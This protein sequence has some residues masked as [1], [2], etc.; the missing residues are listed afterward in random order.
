M[1]IPHASPGQAI[2]VRP[3]G[4]KLKSSVTNTLVK[5]DKLEVI[6]MVIPEDKEIPYHKVPG[7]ITIQCLEGLV[8]LRSN[9]ETKVL[10]P[11][12]MMY[13]KGDDLHALKGMADSSLLVMILL[14]RK[15]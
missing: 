12:Q 5:T 2:D 6:R 13:L 4:E 14:A 10:Q 3:L 1:A 11:G 9:G 15:G 7:E 8:G